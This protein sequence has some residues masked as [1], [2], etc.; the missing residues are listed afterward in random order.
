VTG[1]FTGL[2]EPTAS[3]FELLQAFAPR[4]LLERAYEHA[5]AE[6]YLWHEFGDSNLILGSA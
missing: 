1:L 2:H 6:G 3:H 5:A 4:S